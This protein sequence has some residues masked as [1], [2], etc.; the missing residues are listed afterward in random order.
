MQCD[1]AIDEALMPSW[2]RPPRANSSA[3]TLPP[4]TTT[5][6]V[7]PRVER[8]ASAAAS[9]TAPPGSTTSFRC[10]RPGA[11]RRRPRVG[12]GEPAGQQRRLTAKVSSPGIGASSASQIDRGARRVGQRRPAASERAVSS[13]P[14][15]S[16]G[17]DGRAGRW[18]VPMAQ[19]AIRPPPPQQTSAASSGAP[20]RRGLLR[21][22]QPDR[23]LPGHDQRIVVGR[24]STAPVRSAISRRSP[25]GPPARGRR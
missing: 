3:S 4:E 17:V 5:P 14:A 23:A 8:P 21:E 19:P 15:G 13:K 20:R 1:S 7:R 16:T 2:A 25:R 6:M 10:G 12:D 9:A 18:L 22:L 11:W 24:I